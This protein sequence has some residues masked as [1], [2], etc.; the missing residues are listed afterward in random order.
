MFWIQI[1]LFCSIKYLLFFILRAASHLLSLVPFYCLY[2]SS[3]K[4]ES[5]QQNITKFTMLKNHI[6]F[7]LFIEYQVYNAGCK[8]FLFLSL[9]WM[10]KIDFVQRGFFQQIH[11]FNATFALD[12]N[13]YD[14]LYLSL[15]NY[16]WGKFLDSILFSPP[17]FISDHCFHQHYPLQAQCYSHLSWFSSCILQSTEIKVITTFI[18]LYLRYHWKWRNLFCQLY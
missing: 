7:Y 12:K 3:I 11:C 16:C 13:L 17:F 10:L 18:S 9:C 4:Y 15:C 1:Y 5:E 14:R 2:N 8:R 6:I